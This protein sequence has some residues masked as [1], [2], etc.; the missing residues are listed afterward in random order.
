MSCYSYLMLSQVFTPMNISLHIHVL[1]DVNVPIKFADVT[2]Q[3]IHCYFIQAILLIIL[4]S[5]SV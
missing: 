1:T 2:T 5:I 3:N 4:L